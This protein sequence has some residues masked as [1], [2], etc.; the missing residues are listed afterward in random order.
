MLLDM[1]IPFIVYSGLVHKIEMTLFDVNDPFGVVVKQ[2]TIAQNF[3]IG[4][5]EICSEKNVTLF[6]QDSC[7]YMLKIRIEEVK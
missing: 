5:H 4:E 2:F 3:G 6:F 1:V 7:D